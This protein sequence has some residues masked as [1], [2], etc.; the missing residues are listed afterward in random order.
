MV[1]VRWEYKVSTVA[2][3]PR[4]LQTHLDQDGAEE[5]ELV[6]T[7]PLSSRLLLLFKRPQVLVEEQAGDPLQ[8]EAPPLA[9]EEAQALEADMPVESALEPSPE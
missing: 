7:T 2:M 1:D 6:S 9:E 3:T 5:W 4:D 8:E